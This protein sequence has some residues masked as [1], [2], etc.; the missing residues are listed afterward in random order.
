MRTT[1]LRPIVLTVVLAG[2]APLAM[3]G[4][5]YWMQQSSADS[6]SLYHSN[7]DGTSRALLIPQIAVGTNT[8]IR[9]MATEGDTVFWN[10]IRYVAGKAEET[11]LFK[12]RT[13]GT[14]VGPADSVPDW[15]DCELTGK[16]VLDAQGNL[17]SY[18]S[19]QPDEGS[20]DPVSGAVCVSRLDGSQPRTL[21]K[22]IPFLPAPDIALDLLHDKVYWA[23][24]WD[25]T[26]VGLIQRAN[27]DGTQVQTLLEGPALDFRDNGVELALDVEGDKMYWTNNGRGMIQ[28]AN[29][30]GTD[31]EVIMSGNQPRGGLALDV[32]RI[33]PEPSGAILMLLC[34]VGLLCRR[35]GQPLIVPCEESC[36]CR[37]RRA[38][39]RRQHS[40]RR[41]STTA[42]LV[43]PDNGVSGTVWRPD[44]VPGDTWQ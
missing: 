7:L 41:A 12:A 22:T 35:V 31:V 10:Q 44:F 11:L 14:G 32:P 8:Y 27:L 30:D 38:L 43:L 29:L 28:R 15:V 42:H 21:V 36:R 6:Y 20:S 5:L 18:Q 40:W 25:Q 23:G 24:G 33:I 9:S 3:G 1:S 34:I 26:D 16:G 19:V 39:E 4:K 2:F 37:S 17:Y 13:D